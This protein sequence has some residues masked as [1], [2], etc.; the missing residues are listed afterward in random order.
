MKTIKFLR[1]THEVVN[2]EWVLKFGMIDRDIE[3]NF[4]IH[5][6]DRVNPLSLDEVYQEIL[7]YNGG[8]PGEEMSTNIE[9]IL[10][11]LY[12][13]ICEGSVTAIIS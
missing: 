8:N 9:D 2:G 11:G 5:M 12:N 13:R 6:L 3:D 4:S 1:T 10:Y 7:I